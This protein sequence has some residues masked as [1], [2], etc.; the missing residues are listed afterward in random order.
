M[1]IHSSQIR[2]LRRLLRGGMFLCALA[3]LVL[4]APAAQAGVDSGITQSSWE[5]GD[6]PEG[7]NA[8]AYPSTMVAGSFPTCQASGPVGWIQHDNYGA[9]FGPTFEFEP[10]G[11]AGL[12]PGCFPT[13]DADE[14]FADG[15]A[16]LIVPES[17]TIDPSV[18]VI[19]CPGVNGT[20]LGN[21]CQTLVWGID[22]D[23]EVH[24]HMPNETVGYVNVLMDWNQDGMWGGSSTCPSGSAPEHVLVNYQVPN[25]YDGPLSAIIPAPANFLS[26]PNSGYVWTRFTITEQ[27]V[28]LPW[29]GEGVFED[30]ESEDY[31]LRVDAPQEELDFGDAPDPT[32]ATLQTNNGASHP[33]LAGF[34]LGAS[35]DAEPDGQPDA[36]A[37]GDDLDGNDDEDGVTFKTV[38]L[39]GQQACIDVSLTNT[40]GVA[41][42]SLDAWIDFDA[43]G[44]W[45]DPVEHLWGGT[46]QSLSSGTNTLCFQVPPGASRGPTF[47]RFRLG[48]A[49]AIPPFGLGP[50]GEVEDYQV[51]IEATKWEQPPTFNPESIHPECY[52]GWDEISIYDNENY[53]IIADD[54]ECKDNR[55]ITD[56]HWWGSYLEWGEEEP[57]QPPIAPDSFHIGIWTDVPAG[58]D[59]PW[60]HPGD[61]LRE[62]IVPRTELNEQYDGCDFHPDFMGAPDSCFKY[63]FEI[64]EG[65][66]FYQDPDKDRVY[67]ISISAIYSEGPPMEYLWGWKTRRPEWNDDAVR[68]EFPLQPHPGD[69]YVDGSPIE[70]SEGSWDMAFVLTSWPA[71]P[72]A[73]VV[74][75]DIA[76]TTDV[77]LFWPHVTMDIYGNPVTVVKYNIYR[78]PAPYQAPTPTF[79]LT[80]TGPFIPGQV[81]LIDPGK[82]GNTATNYYY[83]VQAVTQGAGGNDVLSA[84][85]NHIAEFDFKL[86]PGS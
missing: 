8:I 55:P 16:G 9:N 61:M 52:W 11:N 40:A 7:D 74:D 76:N 10:D 64:P 23:I 75:I 15:D 56:I 27:P 57:P 71:E 79:L 47:A 58:G 66:W 21:T 3:L 24:N 72:Q 4:V 13:Y 85:S 31:L 34:N 59:P 65:E 30:G 33:I 5:F 48:N 14:C 20:S 35:I 83:Y 18:I 26:G 46:S 60:S 49:G 82:I 84:L 41:N 81:I 6:A 45:D 70:T 36:S 38:L 63:D 29:T 43:S 44:K 69:A 39:P 28:Q 73:P 42:P 2:M 80:L 53:P 50:A 19:P 77:R 54:W 68:I 62:W 32:Y 22:V 1:N 25:P 67:W 78:D 37:T 12:C 51:Y 17:Y 86:V